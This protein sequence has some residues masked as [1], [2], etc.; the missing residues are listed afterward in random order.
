LP[1]SQEESIIEREQ[2]GVEHCIRDIMDTKKKKK[3]NFINLLSDPSKRLKSTGRQRENCV[4]V[5][6]FAL[7]LRNQ[8]IL[9]RSVHRLCA[10]IRESNALVFVAY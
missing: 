3:K 5:Q 1:E 9:F 7:G 10:T 2:V 8:R 4:D 6:N